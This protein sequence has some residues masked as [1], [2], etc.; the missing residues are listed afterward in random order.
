MPKKILFMKLTPRHIRNILCI[1]IIALAPTSCSDSQSTSFTGLGRVMFEIEADANP[2]A[3][4]SQPFSLTMSSADGAYSHTWRDIGE[5]P[6]LENFYT[7]PYNALSVSGT[8]GE[9]GYGCPCYAGEKTFEIAENEYQTVVIPCKLTQA[10]A[11]I[12]VGAGLS[13]TFP[14]ASIMLHSSGHGYVAYDSDQ[15]GPML[16]M[17]GLTTATLTFEDRDGKQVSVLPAF[18]VATTANEIS[19]ISIDMDAD[20]ILSLECGDSKAR[21]RISGSLFSASAPTIEARGF[22]PGKKLSLVEGFPAA[23]HVVMTLSAPAGIQSANLTSICSMESLEGM[24]AESDLWRMPDALV[25]Y[26]LQVKRLSENEMTI[27]FTSLLE[28]VA[29]EANSK[30]TFL[31]VCR[32]VLGRVSATMELEVEIRSVEMGLVSSQPAIVGVETP[33][34]TLALN[35]PKA[36]PSD[37]EV[38]VTDEHGNPIKQAQIIDSKI[39]SVANEITLQ[40][41]VDEGSDNIPVRI[42]FMGTPKLNTVIEREVEPYD[43]TVD[44]FATAALI[45]FKANTEE[46]TAAIARLASVKANGK[47]A[48]IYM[49][50]EEKGTILIV[51]L[52][53]STSYNI[54]PVVVTNGFTPK[55][56][57]MTEEAAPVPSGDFEDPKDAIRYGNLMSGG[58]YSV[59]PFPVYSQQN[60]VSFDTKWVEKHWANVNAKTF[61]TKASNHN[62]WYMQPS[63]WLDFSNSV[64]GSKSVYIASV[65][66]SLAGPEIPPYAQEQGEFL[67]YNANVPQID[68]RS[69]G[70]LFLGSYS[71]NHATLQEQYKEGVAFKSRPS[72]LNGFF[73]YLPDATVVNDYGILV[74]ELINENGPEPVT[75][76][77]ATA[78]FNNSPDFIAFNVPLDYKFAGVKATKLKMMFASSHAMGSIEEEDAN[79]PVTSD[80][81]HAVSIGSRLWIDNLSFSY[82]Y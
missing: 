33:S 72:S 29:V 26:G 18:E 44:A 55:A 12:E 74:I 5:F 50:D 77:T 27:D 35:T 64:S 16:V 20:S 51:G 6:L 66:W 59:S 41:K 67:P 10:L 21:M 15:D 42:D 13:S 73:K 9:E 32:D 52:E 56:S 45:Y 24:P 68:H 71:F 38:F 8:P 39:D 63:S 4:P 57:A 75:V 58:A 43:I 70:K 30:V 23:S 82:S 7:G 81:E 80:P 65:G 22:T 28:N 61:C 31:A 62:T 54:S 79:V 60:F 78:R 17:P 47:E 69:A 40:F 11:E 53:P 46:M 49:R 37:F 34:V 48:S 19:R 14:P 25:Q 2:L 76:A 36:E 3:P 1:T